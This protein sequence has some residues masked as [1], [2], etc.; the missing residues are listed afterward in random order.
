MTIVRD[1]GTGQVRAVLR[2]DSEGGGAGAYPEATARA[3]TLEALGAGLETLHSGGVPD[4]RAW[5]R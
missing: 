2:G 3:W 5:T 1:P 4:G